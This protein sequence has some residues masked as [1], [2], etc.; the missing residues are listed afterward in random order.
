MSKLPLS[1]FI[2]AVNEGDRIARAIESVRDWVDEVI[3]ID[4]GSKD[5]TVKVSEAAG[6]RAMFHAWPGYGE[7]KRFGEDQCRNDWILNLDADEMISTGLA[8]EIKA[9][10][11][12]GL[13]VHAAYFSDIVEI[14]PG[15]KTPSRFAHKVHS[16]RLYN[17]RFGRFDPSTVHDTVRMERGT[18]GTLNNII[19]HRSARGITHSI[20]KINRYSTMQAENM[21]DRNAVPPFLVLRLLIEMPLGFFKAYVLRGYCLKGTY[22]F[23]NAVDYGFSRFLRLAKTWELERIRRNS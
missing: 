19:E 22:G 4:S 2:I 21:L 10:F 16:I 23:I 9:Q 7:Q 11:A 17:K 12:N 14:L 5:D 20:E 8:A 18:T 15:E 13:P 1:V 3:V 6:A